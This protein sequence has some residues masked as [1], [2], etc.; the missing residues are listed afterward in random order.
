MAVAVEP[1]REAEARI[2]VKSFG[3]ITSVRRLPALGR[4]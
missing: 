3:P 4:P 1:L 2:R